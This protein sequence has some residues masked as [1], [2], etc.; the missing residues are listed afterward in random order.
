[1]GK[2]VNGKWNKQS[3]VTSNKQGDYERIPRT[4]RNT[5]SENDPVFAP[6]ANRYHLYVS[7]AC[8]WAHRALIMRTLKRLN[9]IIDVSIVHPDMLEMGWSFDKN[10]E[11]STGDKL[12]DLEYLFQIYQKSMKNL[13]TS[14]TVPVLWDSKTET[15]VNNES[16]DII[17]IFNSSFN[18][19]TKDHQDFYP[20]KLRV[21]IDELNNEIYHNINNGVYRAG[22]AK[23]QNAYDEAV[24]SVFESLEWIERRL[25]RKKY[26]VGDELTEADIRLIPT[27]LRFDCVYYIHFKCNIKKITEFPN[28]SKYL[29]SLYAINAVKSTLNIDH[30]KRHY[31]F[32]HKHINPLRIIPRGPLNLILTK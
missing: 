2:L 26:L 27:L 6:E 19:L 15:I 10:Y 18:N 16:S 23:T 20:D 8:P 31:Y 13:T 14:V 28:I 5:I 22:F 7:L 32:S 12:Y 21:E 9:N 1:M 24:R 30:I 4:F 17:R 25:E 3:I 11:K 29:E